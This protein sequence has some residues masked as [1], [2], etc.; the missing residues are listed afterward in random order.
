MIL[1]IDGDLDEL[2]LITRACRRASPDLEI[3]WAVD[4]QQALDILSDPRIWARLK[5][6]FVNL[7]LSRRP[8]LEVLEMLRASEDAWMVPVV[9][10]GGPVTRTDMTRIF[11]AGANTCLPRS[12]PDEYEKTIHTEAAFWVGLDRDRWAHPASA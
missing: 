11:E 9:M 12:H 2:N 1:I 3:Q 4:G 6:V 7:Q 8:G 10:V 5:L